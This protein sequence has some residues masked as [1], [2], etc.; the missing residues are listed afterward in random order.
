[1]QQHV[2]GLL[3]WARRVVDIDQLLHGWHRSGMGLQHGMQKQMWVT[4]TWEAEHRLVSYLL[5]PVL[6]SERTMYL[7]P[8]NKAVLLFFSG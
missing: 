4:L 1:V 6:V 8:H 2:V 7:F 5:I 3:L